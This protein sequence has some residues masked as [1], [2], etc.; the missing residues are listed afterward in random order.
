MNDTKFYVATKVEGDK[1]GGLLVGPC[2]TEKQAYAY[3]LPARDL[4]LNLVPKAKTVANLE[5]WVIS[6]EPA[7]DTFPEGKLNSRL[8]FAPGGS[9]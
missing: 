2:D 1:V 5:F 8:E 3:L 7:G 6:C 4:A 9:R